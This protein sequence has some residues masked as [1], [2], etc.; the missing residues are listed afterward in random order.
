MFKV[1]NPI[2]GQHTDAVTIEQARVIRDAFVAD[3][4]KGYCVIPTVKGAYLYVDGWLSDFY[5]AYTFMCSKLDKTPV[6]FDSITDPDSLGLEQNHAIY[7]LTTHGVWSRTFRYNTED[8]ALWH[9]KVH[10]GSVTDWYKAESEVNG[11][12]HAWVTF[13]LTTGEPLEV[14]DNEAVNVLK[15]TILN[16]PDAPTV[17]TTFVTFD[18]LPDGYKSVL[19]DWPQRDAIFSWSNRFYGQI[20]E[21][22]ENRFV[23]PS[24]WPADMMAQNAALR[25]AAAQAAEEKG[26]EL[27]TVVLVNTTDSGDTTW[28]PVNIL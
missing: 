17:T 19:A 24:T 28:T 14:Y 12:H 23:D 2:T 25:A 26:K 9:I 16:D 3:W 5:L 8:G 21:Y 1:F 11:V 20:V 13:D 10:D 27:A 4:V 18:G 22:V 6:A 15:K 7:N